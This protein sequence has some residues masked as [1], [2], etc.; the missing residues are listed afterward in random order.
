MNI[1]LY[2][3]YSKQKEIHTA[4]NDKITTFITA[5]AGRQSGKS[6][7]AMNQ[8]LYW[9]IKKPKS[10]IYWVCPTAAQSIKV[11]K[12]ILNA[13][14]RSG[15]VK[16]HKGSQGDVEIILK[17]GSQI[18]FRSAMQEDSLRGESVDYLILD[19]AAYMKQSVFDE[20]L[21][22]MLN[23]RGKKCL[24]IS[25]P[26]SKNWVYNYYIKGRDSQEKN[27]KAFRFTSSDNPHSN[28][29]I[30]KLAKDNLPEAIYNQE[31][32][33][34]FV[35]GATIFEN[36]TSLSVLSPLASPVTSD[37]YYIGIDIGMK[38]DYTVVAILNQRFE[39]VAMERFTNIKAPALK[40]RLIKTF[41][42]WNPKKIY[43]ELNN[44]GG[45][46]YD[47]LVEM[48]VKNLQGWTTSQTSKNEIINNLIN[49]FASEKIKVL[50]DEDVQLELEA[51]S[52]TFSS[53]GKAKFGAPS[54]FHDDIVM[55]LAIGYECLNKHLYSGKIVFM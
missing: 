30:L 37:N 15:V 20:I 36:I 44:Q 19:E 5:V 38:S 4:C 2:K 16:S 28:P 49:A 1:Q 43:L 32:L 22:P 25:T 33:A 46:I 41:N 17:N 23:V 34:L 11:Y 53:T 35:D 14:I 31:Y 55:A 7:L 10:M 18:K 26:K 8:V 50:N 9:G 40:E 52:M 48:K 27:F 12:Q 21:L 6:L 3:P 42:K 45:P 54:G 24:I 39:F 47:D 29:L 51:Y 13:I